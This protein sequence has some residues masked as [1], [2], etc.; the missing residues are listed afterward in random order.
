M[1]KLLLILS[2]GS[3]TTL[4]SKQRQEEMLMCKEMCDGNAKRFNPLIQVCE[5]HAK[6]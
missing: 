4:Y 2:L 6:N 3:C 1:I 5:C